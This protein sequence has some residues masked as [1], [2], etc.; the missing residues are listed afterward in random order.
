MFSNNV[1]FYFL[2]LIY[3]KFISKNVDLS[4]LARTFIK[5]IKLV[6]GFQEGYI[7]I[8]SDLN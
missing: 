5:K 3:K 1:F 6:D 4:S 7:A 2:F 8:A